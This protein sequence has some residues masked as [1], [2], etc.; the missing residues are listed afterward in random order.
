MREYRNLL[1]ALGVMALLT[2]IGLYLPQILK[3]VAAWGEWGIHEVRRMV[4]YTPAGMEKTADMWKAPMPGYGPPGRENIPSPTQGFYYLLSAFAGIVACGGAAHLLA[5][6]L[7]GAEGAPEGQ[8][9]GRAFFSGE[10]KPRPND[11]RAF[12]P[13]RPPP[14]GHHSV[15]HPPGGVPAG[16]VSRRGRLLGPHGGPGDAERVFRRY[17]R[18]SPGRP[19]AG[20]AL[21][22]VLPSVRDRDHPGRPSP[23]RHVPAPRSF[24]RRRRIVASPFH[25]VGRPPPVTPVP[26]PPRDLSAGG[27]DD[28]PVYPRSASP[29]LGSPPRKEEPHRVPDA[30]RVRTGVGRRPDR[31]IL[32]KGH[33]TDGGGEHG[34]GRPRRHGG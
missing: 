17:G 30:D 33:P 32:G 8:A 22:A 7:T 16:G 27:R 20:M 14:G 15:P 25:E 21:R 28:R 26:P 5:P 3:T 24:L 11:P 19:G 12:R 23:R 10:R 31:P 4:G 9:S 2:P 34:D 13:R 18:P 29:L 6:W 1:I